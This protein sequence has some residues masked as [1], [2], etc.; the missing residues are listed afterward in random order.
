MAAL[1]GGHLAPSVCSQRVLNLRTQLNN[2]IT[3]GLKELLPGYFALVMATGIVSIGA[4]LLN[5]ELVA[6]VLFAF[7]QAAYVILWIL[8]LTRFLFYFPQAREDLADHT[9]GPGFF[10][11]VAGTCVLGSQ[12]V[13]LAGDMFVAGILF[14]VGSILWLVMIYTI[15]TLLITKSDPPPLEEGINGTWLVIVVAT[16]SISVLGTLLAGSAGR[17]EDALLFLTL[18]VYTLGGMLYVL[19][20][21]LIFYRL[22]FFNLRPDQLTAPYWINMGALAISTLAGDTLILNAGKWAFLGE[23]LPFLKGLNILFWATATWWIPLMVILGAWRHLYKRYPLRYEPQYWSL[24]F[25]LGMYTVCTYQLARAL[26]LSWLSAI[27]HYFIYIALAAWLITFVGLIQ[28]L[29]VGLIY[30][31]KK[32]EPKS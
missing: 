14:M 5:I 21:T 23:L 25:P 22:F 20:I 18:A 27:P 17:F 8:Y 19:L 13:I 9:R 12:F 30:P 10:T 24:V 16:Q 3:Q 31:H 1:P 6:R 2:K 32:I 26:D 4:H 28:Q 7:N 11:M 15:F 29:V